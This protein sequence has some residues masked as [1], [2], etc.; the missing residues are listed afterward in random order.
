MKSDAR[1]L[2]LQASRNFSEILFATLIAV[3]N[4][5]YRFCNEIYAQ[6]AE[7]LLWGQLK[8]ILLQL[9][10]GQVQYL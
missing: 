8:L 7:P 9:N 10:R 2:H 5:D 1:S 3:I 4:S 6:L